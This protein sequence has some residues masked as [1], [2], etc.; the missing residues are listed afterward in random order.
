[1][2]SQRKA[3]R[4]RAKRDASRYRVRPSQE[5][6][7]GADETLDDLDIN[8]ARSVQGYDE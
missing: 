8:V 7:E 3:E 4:D 2:K 5:T 1:M 6:A